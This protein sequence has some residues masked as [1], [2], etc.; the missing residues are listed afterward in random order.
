MKKLLHASLINVLLISTFFIT[1]VSASSVQRGS[2]RGTVYQD[3]DGNGI[4][5]GNDTRLSGVN[6]EFTSADGSENVMLVS[7]SN[8]TYGLVGAGLGE[9]SVRAST[10]NGRVT[11][12][13]P[14]SV[15]ISSLLPVKVGVNFCVLGGGTA[16]SSDQSTPTSTT[17]TTSPDITALI[18]TAPS[19]SIV[20]EPPSTDLEANHEISDALLNLQIAGPSYEELEEV[21]E[22]TELN[23][24]VAEV[25]TWLTYVNGFRA[26][27]NLPALREEAIF[28][29]GSANHSRF[30]VLNDLCCAHSQNPQNPLFTLEGNSSGVNGNIFASTWT[31]SQMEHAINFWM[32]APFHALGII[33]PALESVGYGE[34]R[35]DNGVFRYA[36]VLDVRSN[37]VGNLEVPDS[38]FPIYYPADGSETFI[39]RRSLPE[40]PNP[41]ATTACAGFSVPTGPPL[42]VMIGDGDATPR[43]SAHQVFENGNPIESCVFTE[44][45]YTNPDPYAQATGRSI[46]GGRDA[47]VITPRNPLLGAS[48]Y[49]VEVTVNGEQH[50]WE[51]STRGAE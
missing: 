40:W 21:V 10:P 38:M 16:V 11:S 15:T 36:S 12:T 30:M 41:L 19:A 17:T 5:G 28:S 25:P 47:V 18:G 27:A 22:E 9:W 6:L 23:V 4:C 46:L 49:R 2:I 34:Y 33:D 13:N 29:Q 50:S 48:T 44:T 37:E 24:P 39:V 31:G 20:N 43:V 1:F 35:E 51:F 45:T 42:I 26:A 7:G 14:R 3:I 32:S 8:G